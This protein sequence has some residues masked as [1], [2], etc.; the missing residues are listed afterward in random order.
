MIE[1]PAAALSVDRIAQHADFLSAGTNDLTQYTMAAGRENTLVSRYFV[2]DHPAVL[3]LLE[4]AADAAGGLP[5]SLCGELAG[6]KRAIP[7]LV[8]LGFRSL[9][10]P[11]LLVP[12]VKAVVR[13]LRCGNPTATGVMVVP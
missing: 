5:L 3:K 8:E 2:D 11:P 13:G 6:R 12:E 10:V 7:R 4:L 1:T 9:S